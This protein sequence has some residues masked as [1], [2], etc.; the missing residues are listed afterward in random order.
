MMYVQDPN[1]EF[2]I[3]QVIEQLTKWVDDHDK[4]P[5]YIYFKPKYYVLFLHYIGYAMKTGYKQ[6]YFMGCRILLNNFAK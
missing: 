4:L 1:K 6:D 5:E 2:T 3:M